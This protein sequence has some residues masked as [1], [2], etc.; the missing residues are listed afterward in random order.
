MLN[1]TNMV[2]GERFEFT[3]DQ[4][5]FLGSDLG[6]Y[7]VARAVAASSAFPFLLNPL[8][9]VNRAPAPGFSLP[10]E[11]ANALRDREVNRR[12]YEWARHQTEYLDSARRPYVYLMDGGLGDNI[13]LRAVMDAYERS[14]GFLAQRVNG[15]IKRLVIIVVNARTTG[16]DRLSR[17]PRTPRLADVGLATATIAMERYSFETIEAMKELGRGRR[18]AEQS[19]AACQRVLDESCPNAPRLPTFAQS[20]RTC[21]VELSFESIE[22]EQRRQYFLH[23]PTTFYLPKADVDALVAVGQELLER[24]GDF[25]NLLRAIR[26]E[27][28]LGEGIGEKGNC[29]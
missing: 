5:D 26:N 19:V 2:N 13:G 27:P 4:F 11:Y 7:P 24:S 12:R 6:A 9:L 21:V 25:Q 18:Q 10:L 1:A 23:L 3:Q 14:N 16:V 20:M 22:D 17:R 8:G 28:T 15:R 29:S